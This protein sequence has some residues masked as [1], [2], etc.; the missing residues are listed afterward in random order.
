MLSLYF[1]LLPITLFLEG[2]LGR[3]RGGFAALSMTFRLRMIRLRFGS[4]GF[5]LRLM[6]R[7]VSENGDTGGRRPELVPE[8]AEGSGRGRGRRDMLWQRRMSF[9]NR[10]T[11]ALECNLAEPL[12]PGLTPKWRSFIR[13]ASAWALA[14]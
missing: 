8:G 7:T 3:P 10:C 11:A 13:S 5:A 6:I 12:E 14:C 4:L 2:I 1:L 9:F